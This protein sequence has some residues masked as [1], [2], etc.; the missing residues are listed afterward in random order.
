M[1]SGSLHYTTIGDLL[2]QH[3]ETANLSLTQLGDKSGVR[4]GH[5]S[6]IENSE[7][8][9]PKF[10]TLR[11]LVNALNIPFA[12]II[13]LFIDL[14]QKANTL[15]E[16][17]QETINTADIPLVTKVSFKYLES[18]QEDSDTAL[19]KLYA[20]ISSCAADPPL[21]NAMYNV[22]ISYA[23]SH[24]VMPYLAKGQLQSY[25]IE[26]DDFT[27]LTTTYQI[28]KN[29][30]NY[31]NFLSHEENII[32][33]YKLGIHAYVLRRYE[34]CIELCH[35]VILHDK[36]SSQFKGESYYALCNA[37]YY[38]GDY[39][40]A[41]ENLDKYSTFTFPKVEED[42]RFMTGSINGKIGNVD[43]AITQLEDC[44]KQTPMDNLI[45]IVTTLL[46]LYL[47][48]ENSQKIIKIFSYENNIQDATTPFKKFILAQFY[49]LKGDY[50]VNINEYSNAV[51]YYLE[52]ARRFAKASD[53]PIEPEFMKLLFNLYAQKNH[54]MDKVTI[55]MIQ[56]FFDRHNK[57]SF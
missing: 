27:R 56:D 16:I 21:K 25:L 20:L 17:L 29:I 35:H 52:S 37:Y 50:F 28:G 42:V 51:H 30:L 11:R 43:L 48:K 14:D 38:L 45:Y 19:G 24:G 55:E 44:L 57:S 36:T 22:I 39:T 46:E 34:D 32:L 3:R 12:E 41:Q 23:R 8:I 4:K 49:K 1:S 31:S 40:L 10:V 5:I 7:I 18:P 53:T 26:R 33:H 15:Y 13:T 54:V 6:K 47:E 2:R 9:N